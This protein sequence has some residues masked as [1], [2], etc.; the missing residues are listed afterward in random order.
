MAPFVRG[1]ESSSFKANSATQLI[2]RVAM[3]PE[4]QDE[5]DDY[6]AV[7]IRKINEWIKDDKGSTVLA[8]CLQTVDRVWE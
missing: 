2:H 6:L 8:S 1:G 5:N 3:P 7:E 4:A